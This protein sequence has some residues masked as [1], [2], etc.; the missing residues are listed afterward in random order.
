MADHRDPGEP[1]SEQ[2]IDCGF[3]T[4]GVDKVRLQ[5]P[6]PSSQG[7]SVRRRRCHHTDRQAPEP[8]FRAA[9]FAAPSRQAQNL[10][11]YA[12]LL[13]FHH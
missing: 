3:E 11:T 8:D 2:S 5:L 7:H 9:E 6:Q 4:V 10:A 13:Q 12:R 1:P